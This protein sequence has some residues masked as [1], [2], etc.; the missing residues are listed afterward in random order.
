MNKLI[1]LLLLLLAAFSLQAQTGLFNLS[2]AIPLSEADSLLALSGFQAKDTGGD[3]VRYYNNDSDLVDA[4]LVFVE[5]KTQRMIGW[6]IKYNA[7]NT[8]ENDA[9]VMET[10]QELH[11]KTNHFDEET[12][13]LIWFLSTTRTVHVI[14]AEDNSLTVL[15]F[16]NKFPELFKLKDHPQTS[17]PPEK[18]PEVP[19]STEESKLPAE[20]LLDR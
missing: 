17:P 14:Y 3:I 2:Y 8:E 10:L 7:N 9:F 13:Q 6:F 19:Q 11:G 4:I 20:K 1:I 15:Y 16:D 18:T 12:Q 5:P